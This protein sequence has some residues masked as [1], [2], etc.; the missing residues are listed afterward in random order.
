[1]CKIAKCIHKKFQ[2]R[3]TVQL[4][5]SAAPTKYVWSGVSTLESRFNVSR[6]IASVSGIL[7]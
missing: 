4:L 2:K 5:N 3:R 7:G 6:F 1:M